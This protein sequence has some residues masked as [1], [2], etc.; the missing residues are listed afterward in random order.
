MKVFIAVLFFV[1]ASSS[2]AQSQSQA[3]VTFQAPESMEITAESVTH[4]Q[5]REYVNKIAESLNA[6]V[7]VAYGSLSAASEGKKILA[8]VVSDTMTEDELLSSLNNHHAV[9]S[10]RPNRKSRL[11]R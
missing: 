7:T 3:L 1:F 9:L 4:G 8:L 10:A 6:R 11:M 2:Q 5:A